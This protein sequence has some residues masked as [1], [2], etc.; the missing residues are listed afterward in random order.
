[1]VENPKFAVGIVVISVISMDSHTAT[2]IFGCPSMSHLLLDTFFEFGVVEDIVYRTSKKAKSFPSHTALRAA[3]ISVSLAL[4][5][6]PAYT[7]RPW[8]RG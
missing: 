6:T 3:L 2:C 1:M 4:S 5:Q 7:A 8:I